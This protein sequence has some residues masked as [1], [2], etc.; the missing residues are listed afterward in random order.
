MRKT[1]KTA[2]MLAITLSAGLTLAG[3]VHA[4]QKVMSIGTGGTGGV[5]YPLGGAVANV[6]SKTLP[7]VQATA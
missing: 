7:N 3:I 6:L 1:T 4:Q 2:V 5:Y